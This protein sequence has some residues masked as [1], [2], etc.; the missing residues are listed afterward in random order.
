MILGLPFSTVCTTVNKV[1]ASGMKAITI[2]AQTISLGQSD[3]IVAGGME[4]M[5]NA[6]FYLDKARSGYNYGHQTVYDGLQKDGLWDAKYQCGMGE[7]GDH[8]AKLFNLSRQDQ[9]EF[10]ISSY[11]KAANA[12]KVI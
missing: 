4:S 7:C 6:P 3:V 10:A 12:V 11:K 2:A 5:S 9:D 1:C 8:V